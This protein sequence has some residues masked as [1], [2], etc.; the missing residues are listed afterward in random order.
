MEGPP[1]CIT[2]TCTYIV[3]TKCTCIA[4]HSCCTV[5]TGVYTYCR[6]HVLHV[7]I[8]TWLSQIILFCY[9]FWLNTFSLAQL[10][11]IG[12]ASAYLISSPVNVLSYKQQLVYDQSFLWLQ[13]L[14]SHLN[15]YHLSYQLFPGKWYCPY[16]AVLFTLNFGFWSA[17]HH[18]FH[19]D[20]LWLPDKHL[21]CFLLRDWTGYS[22]FLEHLSWLKVARR[23]VWHELYTH[24][25]RMCTHFN[26]HVP[27]HVDMVCDK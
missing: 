9:T 17:P 6:I 27:V 4:Q 18:R 21:Q 3:Y 19:S 26:L 2:N 24:L 25:H 8:H 5:N 7:C 15:S 20:L 23:L 10:L 13:L 11:L 22:N 1:I 16:R 14:I 12:P